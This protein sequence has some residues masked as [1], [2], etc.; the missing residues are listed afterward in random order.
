R[1]TLGLDQPLRIQRARCF[2][3]APAIQ[4]Q[5]GEIDFLIGPGIGLVS[6]EDALRMTGNCKNELRRPSTPALQAEQNNRRHRLARRHLRAHRRSG[7][8]YFSSTFH[9]PPTKKAFQ[10]VGLPS[11]SDCT[12][13]S[14]VLRLKRITVGRP[15]ASC[16]GASSR[17]WYF[18]SISSRCGIS[19]LTSGAR[20]SRFFGNWLA[21][22]NSPDAPSRST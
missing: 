17:K 7:A 8:R 22:R 16:C 12:Y 3:L 9:L 5:T 20:V 6:H 14:L 1:L 21:A 10:P 19:S 11:T 18:G 15:S 13:C 4:R 2:S